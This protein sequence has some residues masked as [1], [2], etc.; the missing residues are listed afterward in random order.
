[1]PPKTKT[2][3]KPRRQQAK[4]AQEQANK[5]A[6]MSV[7]QPETMMEA[8]K[9]L[10]AERERLQE[11]KTPV[12]ALHDEAVRELLG[13]LQAGKRVFFSP[14]PI[15]GVTRRSIWLQ[16][17]TVEVLR[18]TGTRLNIQYSHLVFTAF[19][20]FLAKRGVTFDGF[21]ASFGG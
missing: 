14:N 6:I 3:P 21:P 9:E 2:K 20:Q 5:L 7:I 1:M 12:W 15:Q 18:E 13:D 10:A 11:S 17:Q 19:I 16:T 8:F 4:A